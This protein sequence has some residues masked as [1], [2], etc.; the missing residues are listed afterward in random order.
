MKRTL[1]TLQYTIL[2]FLLAIPYVMGLFVPLMDSDSAHHAN[3]ALHM[4]KNNNFIDLVDKGKDY[5]DKPH[6]LFWLAGAFYYIFGVNAFAYKLPSFLMSIAA[7]FATK[8]LGTRLY[9]NHTGNL[10]ALLLAS[11][12]AFIIACNDV[13]MDAILTSCIILATWQLVEVVHNKKW[14]NYVGAALF[15]A[16]GFS[17]KGQVGIVM[18]AIAIFFYLLHRRDLALIFNLRWLVVGVLLAVFMLPEL[19]AFYM[20]FDKH[21]EKVIRGMSNISG[22]KFILWG[23]NIERLDGTSW[24]GGQKDYFFYFHTLLWAFLPWSLL[25]Y[26][27]IG[28]RIKRLAQT[29]LAYF[30]N[31]EGL[32]IGTIVLIFVLISLSRFQLPHYLNILFPFISI[33]TAEK[34][35]KL[36]GGINNRPLKTVY[37]VQLIVVILLITGTL[38]LNLWAFPVTNILVAIAGTALF[39]L[40]ISIIIRKEDLF[41]KTIMMSVVAIVLVNIMLN[42]NFYPKLI[43]YQGGSSLAKVVK[44]ENIPVD[45]IAFYNIHSFA[46]DFET[47]N[48]TKPVTLQQLPERRDIS[49]VFTNETGL[50]SLKRSLPPEKIY[51]AEQFRITMLTLPFLNPRTRQGTLSKYYLAGIK[52]PQP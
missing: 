18:P 8:K 21:P 16:M 41:V 43:G 11:A 35:L 9:D 49:W 14:Y 51:E 47:N 3:I 15:L 33:L 50:D 7:V 1:D 27:A 44:E 10:A 29:R 38:A 13:R 39:A 23:Q 45:Q 30:K 52:R 19:Y 48:L 22:V 34:L 36:S 26:Y 6:L 20:Q 12:Q 25:A 42:G 32:T 24:G 4:Y 2:F 31:E 5:L 17:T 46:F 40:L 37:F 28:S